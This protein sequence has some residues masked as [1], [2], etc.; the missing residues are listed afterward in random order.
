LLE[1]AGGCEYGLPIRSATRRDIDMTL[2]SF[3]EMMALPAVVCD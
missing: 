1:S 2:A 3:S